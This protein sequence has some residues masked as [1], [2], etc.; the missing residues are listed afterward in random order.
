M[1]IWG[2]AID[3]ANTIVPAYLSARGGL[4]LPPEPVI[5]FHPQCPCGALK[6][7]AMV[8]LLSDPV[9][10]QPSG[11]IHRTFLRHDGSGKAETDKPK[12]MLGPWGV[13]RLYEPETAGIGIAEGIET[14]LAVAQRIGWGPVWSTCTAGGFSKVPPLVMRTLNIFIDRDDAGVSQ[15]EA[16]ACA[17]RWVAADLEVYIHAPAEGTDW[18]DVARGVVP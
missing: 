6:L 8:A 14:A 5:R 7:P 13:V 1:R 4:C 16:E 17:E 11:G 18:C 10:G 12:M 9:T 3:P 2:E 15:S